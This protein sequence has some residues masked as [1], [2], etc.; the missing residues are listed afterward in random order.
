M[1]H[2]AIKIALNGTDWPVI[3]EEIE[4]M[5]LDYSVMA[6]DAKTDIEVHK[7]ALMAAGVGKLLKRLDVKKRESNKSA[8]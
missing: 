5:M 3:R 7:A 1:S 8:T 4:E 2:P 6:A